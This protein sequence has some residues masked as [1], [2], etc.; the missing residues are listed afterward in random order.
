MSLD[1]LLAEPPVIR[2]HAFAAMG[3]ILLGGVQM[4]GVKGTAR[5]RA[6]GWSWVALM[7]LVVGTSFFI[8]EIQQWG[9]W[10]WIHLL[11]ILTAVTLPAAVSAA[12][13]GRRRAHAQA[14]IMLYVFALLVTGVFTLWPGRVMHA[15]IFGA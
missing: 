2:I 8:H 11:S 5:H 6:L 4:A 7:A 13:R 15:V 9:R 1:P 10:S 12:R 14:M 3:A